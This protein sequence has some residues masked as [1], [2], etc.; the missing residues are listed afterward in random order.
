MLRYKSSGFRIVYQPPESGNSPPNYCDKCDV[1][2]F[3]LLFVKTVAEKDEN[4]LGY[5]INQ[6][7]TNLI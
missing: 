2:L 7:N 5:K 3:C 6:Q 1:E 4:G